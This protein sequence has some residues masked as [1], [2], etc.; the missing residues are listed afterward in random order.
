[1][2]R[3]GA[4]LGALVLTLVFAAPAAAAQKVFVPEHS[5]SWQFEVPVTADEWGWECSKQIYF[6]ERGSSKL[7]L[8]YKN[9]VKKRE[10]QPDG[11]AWPWIRG[12]VKDQAVYYFSTGK[13]KTGKVIRGWLRTRTRLHDHHLGGRYPFGV[14]WPKGVDL[15]TWKT[16]A[17]GVFDS[18][19]HRKVGWIWRSMGVEKAKLTVY[20]QN[21]QPEDDFVDWQQLSFKGPNVYNDKKVCKALG[22]D[23][24]GP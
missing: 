13:G 11:R 2:R 15:E 23:Y 8:W 17:T 12:L 21:R 22:L 20:Q 10:M 9:G 6:G 1:M 18:L 3:W 19:R 16:T 5:G 7:W 4:L 14:P 24:V